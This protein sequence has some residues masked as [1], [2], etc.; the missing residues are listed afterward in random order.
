MS[1]EITDPKLKMFME[2]FESQGV[3]F[4]DMKTGEMITTKEVDDDKEEEPAGD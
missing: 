2:F 4:V 3:K 1:K